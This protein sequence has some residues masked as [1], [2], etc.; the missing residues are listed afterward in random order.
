MS[1]QYT[2]HERLTQLEEH[3]RKINRKQTSIDRILEQLV[4]GVKSLMGDFTI[5]KKKKIGEK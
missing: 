4:S 3:L 1:K 2:T 5:E